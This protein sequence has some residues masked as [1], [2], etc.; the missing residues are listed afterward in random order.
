MGLGVF[1]SLLEVVVIH[2]LGEGQTGRL[3]GT[4]ENGCVLETPLTLKM[5]STQ[6][7]R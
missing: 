1:L 2:F 7:P 6:S 5:L 3:L 4:H